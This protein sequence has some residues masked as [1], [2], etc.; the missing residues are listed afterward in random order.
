MAQHSMIIQDG[1]ALPILTAF[2][3]VVR[4][5]VTLSAGPD[6]P[7]T[8][9]PCQLWYDTV[10][11]ILKMRSEAN[12][13]WI[14]M[15]YLDQAAGALRLLQGMLVVDATGA[16][17]GRIDVQTGGV[18]NAGTGTVESLISPAKL[19]AAIVALAP[20]GGMTGL[21]TVATDSGGTVSLSGLTLTGYK[22]LR[23]TFNRVKVG[24]IINSGSYRLDFNGL[25][26]LPSLTRNTRFSGTVDIDLGNGI[27]TS[28]IQS[29][30]DGSHHNVGESGITTASTEIELERVHIATASGQ[31]SAGEYVV[32][33]VK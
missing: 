19:K 23:V 30:S 33:G 10:N 12:D 4:A 31:F 21:G 18:W 2:N 11:N 6:A 26:I 27:Q 8:T 9:Y 28:H 13:G 24:T 16:Q 7:E 14:D 32:Y 5:L 29:E 20:Q 1:E 17:K 3:D 25:T 15:F 22:F